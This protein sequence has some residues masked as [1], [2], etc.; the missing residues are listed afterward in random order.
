LPVGA[1]PTSVAPKVPS[2]WAGVEADFDSVAPDV[3][4]LV[5]SASNGSCH[6]IASSGAD[7]ATPLASSFKLIVLDALAKA[8]QAGKVSWNEKL[9]VTSATKSV[10]SGV[11][12]AEPD[13]T[14]ISVQNVASDMISISDNTAADMLIS[15]LGR[16]A[17]ESVVK[18]SGTSDAALDDPF[19]TTR[20]RF[21]L[22]AYQWPQLADRYLALDTAGR[23]RLLTT[24]IDRVPLDKVP[25]ATWTV[26]RDI[27]SIEW[28]ASPDA[29]CRVYASLDS[30]ASHPRL[31]PL[32]GI[33]TLPSLA[34]L[35]ASTWRSVWFK[36]G[37]EPGVSSF[38]YLATT[39]TGKTFVVSVL[40]ENPKGPIPASTSEVIGG[41]VAGAF[42]LAGR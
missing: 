12:Q 26:P 32:A 20:E 23:L 40:A 33:L 36:G 41:A 4:F 6:T 37:S 8:I 15:L 7:T 30:M 14:R 22:E 25:T 35:P 9:T 27:D 38:N 2:T 13:G 21:V 24:T 39:R 3:R 18:A 5:A 28:F 11:L 29:M 31:K 34:D 1:T 17:I 19:L 16:S 42:E 10:K